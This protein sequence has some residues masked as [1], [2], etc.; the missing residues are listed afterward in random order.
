MTNTERIVEKIKRLRPE[1]QTFV[2]NIMSY[3][4]DP[5]SVPADIVAQ[6]EEA[7]KTDELVRACISKE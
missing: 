3:M 4:I 2:I 5:A 6:I 1:D 7:A